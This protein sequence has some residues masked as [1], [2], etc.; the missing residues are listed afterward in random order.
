MF[1]LKKTHNA[2]DII[3]WL[4]SSNTYFQIFVMFSNTLQRLAVLFILFNK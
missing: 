1:Y 3:P 2:A 4:P